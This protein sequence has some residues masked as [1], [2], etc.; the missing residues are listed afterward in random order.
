MT[1]DASYSIIP[2]SPDI[3]SD[4]EKRVADPDRLLHVDCLFQK[5]F[6]NRRKNKPIVDLLSQVLS[7]LAEIDYFKIQGTDFCTDLLLNPFNP[8]PKKKSCNTCLSALEL[9]EQIQNQIAQNQNFTEFLTWNQNNPV[10]SVDPERTKVTYVGSDG[11]SRV[12]EAISYL[13]QFFSPSGDETDNSYWRYVGS[14]GVYGYNTVIPTTITVGGIPSGST[15]SSTKKLKDLIYDMLNP[16]IAPAFTSFSIASQPTTIEVGTIITGTRIFTW[17]ISLGPGIVNTIDI[18]DNTTA[19]T[20]LAGTP[21]DGAQTVTLN[22]IQL[23]SNGSTQS[24]KLIANNTNPVSFINSANYIATARFLR[25]YGPVASTPTN[26][27]QVR[28]LPNDFQT[29]G[30]SFGLVT[31]TTRTKFDVILPPG[32]TI[33]S[34]IDTGN[35]NANITTSYV[36]IGTV[37]VLDAGGASRVYN[38]YELS[39]GTPYPTSTTHLITTA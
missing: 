32:V 10:T 27:T 13:G 12:Y 5:I 22:T 11:H 2:P 6:E 35:L 21:N 25:F 4:F 34:V 8:I 38:Q 3:L 37:N 29:S 1:V 7:L 28:A 36:L 31:G 24:W 14:T 9:Y 39:L 18:Y 17:S 16:P 20:L 30:N 33:V 15:F 23:N 26:S 19:S